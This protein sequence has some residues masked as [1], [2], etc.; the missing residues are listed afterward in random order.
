MVAAI[1]GLGA[2]AV[3]DPDRFPRAGASGRPSTA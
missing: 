1:D 3:L 2:Q